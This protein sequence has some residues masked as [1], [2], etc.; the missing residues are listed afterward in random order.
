MTLFSLMNPKGDRLEFREDGDGI[1]ELRFSGCRNDLKARR[2]FSLAKCRRQRTSGDC[3]TIIDRRRRFISFRSLIYKGKDEH[4][5]RTDNEIYSFKCEESWQKEQ[6]LVFRFDRCDTRDCD[7]I[8]SS[9]VS[10]TL[11]FHWQRRGAGWWKWA[12][13][14]QG[15]FR[16]WLTYA[17]RRCTN[18]ATGRFHRNNSDVSSNATGQ[19]RWISPR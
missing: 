17:T 3:R 10:P 12:T 8:S 14:C 7:R 1:G 6:E 11:E 19:C 9:L 13:G 4:R 2:D 15:D 18:Q 16:N 5:W